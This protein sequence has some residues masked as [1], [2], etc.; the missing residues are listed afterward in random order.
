MSKTAIILAAGRGTR[1][2]HYTKS[3]PKCLLDIKGKALI[4]RQLVSLTGAG[5]EKFIIVGGYHFDQLKNFL[6]SDEMAR[7]DTTL[8]YN[9]FFAVSNSVASLWFA[10]D[11]LNGDVFITN[12]DT[13]YESQILEKM[14]HNSENYVFG[15]D[16]G[17]YNDADYGVTI[18][19]GYVVDM[20]K[21]IPRNEISAEYIGIALIRN[22]GL[23]TFKTLLD[24]YMLS[25]NLDC[26]WE[27]IFISLISKGKLISY[28]DVSDNVWF[29]IDTPRDYRRSQR[30]F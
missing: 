4:V 18:S 25:G 24:G 10:R 26:W 21:D 1:L 16:E 28:E 19:D 3:T 5:I 17:R 23:E 29:E 8:I 22:S 27:D 15:I 30:F 12:S 20:G 2:T 13:Y 11:Y 9:P 14:S 6:E 7:F